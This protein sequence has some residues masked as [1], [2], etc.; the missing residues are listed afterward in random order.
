MFEVSISI[1]IIDNLL[2]KTNVN[3]SKENFK[4]SETGTRTKDIE[5]NNI[6]ASS[7]LINQQEAIAYVPLQENSLNL[8]IMVPN[9]NDRYQ[10]LKNSL[11][12]TMTRL[13]VV[14]KFCSS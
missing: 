4:I 7:T 9:P 13:N 6:E 3:N 11:F 14:I 1:Q 10:T 12:S 5:E 8:G 2:R